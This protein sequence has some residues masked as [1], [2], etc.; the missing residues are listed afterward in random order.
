VQGGP[1][2]LSEIACLI[3]IVASPGFARSTPQNL[4]FESGSV[5]QP[6][7]GWSL[8]VQPATAHA[9]LLTSAEDPQTGQ[10]SARLTLDDPN[11][12][13][14]VHQDFDATP[15]RG[16]L[17]LLRVAIRVQSDKSAFGDV[18]IVMNDKAGDLLAQRMSDEFV[19]N[20]S[21]RIRK[22]TFTVPANA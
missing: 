14:S 9:T 6:P 8:T 5:G 2:R 10:G 11:A 7:P 16:K 21:W 13:A 15:Y 3:L 17:V 4:D 1:V 18:R 19:F 12:V 22:E 20:G